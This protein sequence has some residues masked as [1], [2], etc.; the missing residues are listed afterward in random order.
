MYQALPSDLRQLRLHH[1]LSRGRVAAHLSTPQI[2]ERPIGLRRNG[3]SRASKRR[4][5]GSIQIPR[6][7]RIEKKPPKISSSPRGRRIQCECGWRSHRIGCPI[8]SGSSCSSRLN[9][10]RSSCFPSDTTLV[11]NDTLHQRRR[12]HPEGQPP[13]SGQN[14]SSSRSVERRKATAFVTASVHR[15]D[16]HLSKPTL[17]CFRSQAGDEPCPDSAARAGLLPR[18]AGG[19]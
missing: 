15:Q 13:A 4:P 3:T 6:P 17:V 8:R 5:S 7:G 19:R 10:C 9:A 11:L 18:R 12:S 16:R 1:C 2:V 14:A